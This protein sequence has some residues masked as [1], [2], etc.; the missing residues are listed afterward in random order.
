[1]DVQVE[2]HNSH[3]DL[4]TVEVAQVEVAQVVKT[5]CFILR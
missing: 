5:S 1:M 2:I 4:K 3:F